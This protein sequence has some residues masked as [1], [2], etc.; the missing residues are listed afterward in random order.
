MSETAP[1]RYCGRDF[2]AAELDLIRALAAPRDPAPGGRALSR[3]VCERLGWRKPDGGL[4]D[5]SARVALL[6]MQRD[7]LLDLL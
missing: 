1:R 6:R 4:K 3:A 5:M 2:S 7:G